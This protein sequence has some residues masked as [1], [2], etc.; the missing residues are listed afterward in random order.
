MKAAHAD[1]RHTQY[2]ADPSNIPPLSI[3][4][5]KNLNPAEKY[6]IKKEVRFP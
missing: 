6:R 2:P 1:L 5:W 4:I 3:Y